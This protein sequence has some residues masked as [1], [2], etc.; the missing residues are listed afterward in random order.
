MEAE[1]VDELPSGKGWQYEPKYDGFRCLVFRRAGKVTLQSKKQKPLQRYF[2][3]VEAGLLALEEDDFV[4]DGEIVIPGESFEVLQLRLHPAASR[5]RKLSR[6]YPARVILFD[7][8]ARKGRNL[9]DQSLDDRRQALKRFMTAVGKSPVLQL[10]KAATT[11]KTARK[12]L[13]QE[14]LDGIIAKRRDLEYQPG[15]RSMQKFKLWKTVDCVVGGVYFKKN[16]RALD[17][18]LLGLYDTDGLFH[19]VGRCRV[20]RDAERMGGLLQPVMGGRGFTGR[21]PGGKNR[22]SGSEREAVPLKPV[23]VVEVS[24]DHVT[25]RFMRHGARL[26]RFRQDKHPEDCTMDQID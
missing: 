3:E 1:A 12:W 26:L 10:G 19:Y 4:L 23:L 21:K 11:E 16:S 2:P 5:A 15:R 20:G 6:E 22:W 14:G 8:L 17:S 24:A 25:S 18:L 9:L 7:I 13:G